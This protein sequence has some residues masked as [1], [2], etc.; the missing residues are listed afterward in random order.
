[1]K[2]IAQL[3]GQVIG[4]AV[5]GIKHTVVALSPGYKYS[6]GIIRFVTQP[7]VPGSSGVEL[8]DEGTPW[9]NTWVGAD[10]P[11]YDYLPGWPSLFFKGSAGIYA[12][13]IASALVGAVFLAWAA[14][15]ALAAGSAP[16]RSIVL[17]RRSALLSER[18]ATLAGVAASPSNGSSRTTDPPTSPTSSA[19]PARSSA[20]RSRRPALIGRRPTARSNASTAP[21][22]RSGHSRATRT[23]NQSSG[24]LS[25]PGS[26]N[27]IATGPTP[28]SAAPRPSTDWPTSLGSTA[29][30]CSLGARRRRG[31]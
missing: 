30:S 19:I 23:P 5:E 17:A 4:Y 18:L 1:M 26:M 3:R 28:E 6:L 25:P 9:F 22:P 16:D 12:M 2:A 10:N 24:T 15:A 13:R 31:R 29:R 20:S 27:T 7:E 21:S 14:Q 11:T 8:G